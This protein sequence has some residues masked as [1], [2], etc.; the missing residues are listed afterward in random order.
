MIVAFMVVSVSAGVS[1]PGL[2]VPFSMRHARTSIAADKAPAA[3]ELAKSA[4]QIPTI[5]SMGTNSLCAIIGRVR[6]V[7][8]TSHPMVRYASATIAD[9]QP[10]PS[11]GSR[12]QNRQGS[13]R[14]GPPIAL[15]Y[16]S[17][18]TST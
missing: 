14:K 16:R 13:G 11:P 5:V 9:C 15:D 4:V 12:Q 3:S 2:V 8:W 17:V 6:E 10:S 18:Q 1:R 7:R